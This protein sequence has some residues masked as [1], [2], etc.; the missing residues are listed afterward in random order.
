MLKE[1]PTGGWAT[2]T[3]CFHSW[4]PLCAKRLE[5]RQSECHSLLE[6]VTIWSYSCNF[7]CFLNPEPSPSRR[8]SRSLPPSR[9][10]FTVN[11]RIHWMLPCKGWRIQTASG[12]SGYYGAIGPTTC[13][14]TEFPNCTFGWGNKC[15]NPQVCIHALSFLNTAFQPHNTTR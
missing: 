2:K 12:A 7:L 11:T 4:F 8:T 15:G 3:F 13:S 5:K 10:S 6:L 1:A 9:F 14:F